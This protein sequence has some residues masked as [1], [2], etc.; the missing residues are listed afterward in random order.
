M[1]WNEA[2]VDFWLL[3]FFNRPNHNPETCS[4]WA[5]FCHIWICRFLFLN[6][7]EILLK[8]FLILQ[9]WVFLLFVIIFYVK[10]LFNF[11][12]LRIFSAFIFFSVLFSLPME[13]WMHFSPSDFGLFSGLFKCKFSLVSD[14]SFYIELGEIT[15]LLFDYVLLY[16]VEPPS[17]Q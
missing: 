13:N 8:H 11:I 5:F 1:T 10:N 4:C 9:Y 6:L 17:V 15:A 2:S 3:S 7:N 16:S 14:D 12:I